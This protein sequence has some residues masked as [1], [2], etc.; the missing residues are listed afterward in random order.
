[1]TLPKVEELEKTTDL[2][3]NDQIPPTEVILAARPGGVAWNRELID[4]MKFSLQK[5]KQ[6]LLSQLLEMEKIM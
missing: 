2:L 3:I 1:L 6:S 4:K 5:I